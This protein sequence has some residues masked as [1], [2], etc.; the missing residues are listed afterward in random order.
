MPAPTPDKVIVTH[1][2]KLS[3]K[4]GPAGLSAIDA[5]VKK[6][7]Q[8]DAARGLIT[9]TVDLSSAADAR[10]YGFTAV[11]LDRID[12]AKRHKQAIDKVYV[13][14][15]SPAYLMLLGAVDV[16][17]HVPLKNPLH[18]PGVDDDETADGDVP[19]ACS[20]AYSTDP[21]KYV[22]P[23]RVVGRLPDLTGGSDPT[24]LIGLLEA[25]ADYKP[26]PA[27]D[28]DAHLGLSAAAWR[29]SSEKSLT[30]LFG[31]HPHLQLS[32]PVV[33]PSKP[34]RHLDRLTHF[35]N[36]H[37]NTAVPRF[38]GQDAFGYPVAL[39]AEQLTGQVT[40]GAV[41]AA[42]CCYGAELYDPAVGG[43]MGVCNT[44]LREKAYGFFGSSTIAYGPEDDTDLADLICQ[45]FL[46]HVRAGASL[47]RACLQARLDYVSGRTGPLTGHDLKT[48]AQF[49][50]LGDPAVTP[51]AAV[52]PKV[53]VKPVT[54]VK[55]KGLAGATAAAAARFMVERFTRDGR[56]DWLRRSA[57][58]LSAAAY[59][60]T[61][62]AAEYALVGTK[63]GKAAEP[64]VVKVLRQV[65]AE[66]ALSNPTVLRFDVAG[67][68]SRPAVKASE[69]R[70]KSTAIGPE[71][72]RV[73]AV[74]ERTAPPGGGNAVFIR[75]FEAVE[76]EGM[77]S[78]RKFASR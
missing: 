57:G 50:L 4:Y 34:V 20:A 52:T 75:G 24:Y 29:G 23:T 18:T 42:E 25:A 69:T 32:P 68:A 55:T 66:M 11:P 77:L 21:R 46:K 3:G 12:D 74:M 67:T 45:F 14:A 54:A 15:E 38:T 9:V 2:A 59:A 36:C 56:R 48:L 22:A 40:E 33:H 73:Y 60:V 47:G 26:R 58:V 78:V 28:Y 30:A 27:A 72:T 31:G 10:K 71:A 64:A 1:K 6:L 37:G 49:H 39:E 41:V 16:I 76:S 65:A 17:P 35:I 43:H 8:T 63:K 13:K 7:T 61:D 5:A 70:T 51:V 53:E 62:A 19:Y 44:Y